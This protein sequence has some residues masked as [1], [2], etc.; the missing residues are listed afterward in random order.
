M[1]VCSLIQVT[2]IFYTKFIGQLYV[3]TTKVS[4]DIINL[5]Y[6][7]FAKPII[8]RQPIYFF[9][10]NFGLESFGYNSMMLL[11]ILFFVIVLSLMMKLRFIQFFLKDNI[12]KSLI[13]IYILVF[14]V[15]IFGS[16]NSQTSG[17]Y[18]VI[19][20]LL[21]LLIIFYLSSNFP[22]KIFNYFFSILI[23]ISIIAGVYEF[24]PSTKNVRIQYIKYLDCINCPKWKSD[25]K[26]WKVDENSFLHVWPYPNKRFKLI[27]D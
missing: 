20:G 4:I 27:K 16:D 18:A 8:G 13:L 9:Y 25:V 21:F 6:N 14:C 24:R 2:L 17:R 11:F 1:I 19:P 26:K 10:E 3:S 15:V 5:T 7:F 23:F 22:S 12:F